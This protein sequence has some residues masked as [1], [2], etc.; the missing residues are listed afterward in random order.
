MP[1]P[2]STKVTPDGSAPVCESDGVGTPFE[3]T[4]NEPADPAVKVADDA[5]VITGAAVTVRVNA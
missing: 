1:S 5:D 3:I 2:L 4:V